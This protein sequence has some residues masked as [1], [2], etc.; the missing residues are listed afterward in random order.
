MRELLIIA[1]NPN[2]DVDGHT[3]LVAAPARYCRTAC[4]ALKTSP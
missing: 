4:A 1:I 2:H 3:V